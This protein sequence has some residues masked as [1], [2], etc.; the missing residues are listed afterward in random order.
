MIFSNYDGFEDWH[1]WVR[2]VT[3][4]NALVINIETAFYRVSGQ[5]EKGLIFRK[6][7]AK[8]RRLTLVEVL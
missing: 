5:T 4:E 7:L 8:S 2:L 6:R 1:L 3:K